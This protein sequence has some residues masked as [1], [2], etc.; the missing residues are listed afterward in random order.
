MTMADATSGSEGI[1]AQETP[2]VGAADTGA[3][4]AGGEAAVAES[5]GQQSAAEGADEGD[6]G[7]LD[8]EA[9]FAD[10]EP[11]AAAPSDDDDD[12]DEPAAPVKG[13]RA[14]KRIRSL[15]GKVKE[16]SGYANQVYAQ[17]QTLVEQNQQLLHELQALRDGYQQ[18]PASDDPVDGFKRELLGD[19]SS[20]FEER[21]AQF[22]ER[23]NRM[24]QERAQAQQMRAQ[25]ERARQ[26][27][28]A[29]DAAISE[30]IS[31]YVDDD[32]FSQRQNDYADMVMTQMAMNKLSPKAAAQKVRR[33]M[34]DHARGV[35]RKKTKGGKIARSQA[36]PA[37]IAEGI[38]GAGGES[39]PSWDAMQR[40]NYKSYV[41]WMAAGSP[42]LK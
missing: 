4:D 36:A 25:R 1:A 6:S 7:G 33:T 42:P 16:L 15:N 35:V 3:G 31:P 41:Q 26:L 27:N 39:Y 8:L 11:A 2:D 23:F 40:N 34:M 19:A 5:D 37:P 38:S 29:V 17:N 14:N 20:M 10:D 30:V 18:Q 22:D 12:D 9:L 21:L 13:N 24:E 28:A 32:I